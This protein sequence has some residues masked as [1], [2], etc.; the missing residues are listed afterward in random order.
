MT[1]RLSHLEILTEEESMRAALGHLLPRIVPGVT[2]QIRSLNSK[3]NLKKRLPGL[4]SGYAHWPAEMD[5]GVVVVVDHDD[6]DCATLRSWLD[7]VA[8]NA[9]FSVASVSSR[10]HGSILNRI[11]IEE[12]EAWFFGDVDALTSAY[13]RVP[14]SLGERAGFR[15][16]DGIDGAWEKL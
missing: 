3:N 4:L 9:G 2:F 16:A 8:M 15:D 11:A 14:R 10:A 13:P 12:L 5:F 1:T 6:D 7:S